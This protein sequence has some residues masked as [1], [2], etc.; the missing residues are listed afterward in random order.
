MDRQSVQVEAAHRLVASAIFFPD[1]MDKLVSS[2][3][4]QLKWMSSAHK[5]DQKA[6]RHHIDL[7]RLDLV[8]QLD[9]M[10]LK[11]P[12]LLPGWQER[13]RAVLR[14][15]ISID[16][17]DTFELLE[18]LTGL[19][20]RTLLSDDD[21]AV[22]NTR[23]RVHAGLVKLL[24]IIADLKM[25]RI[26][27]ADSWRSSEF[28]AHWTDSTSNSDYGYFEVLRAIHQPQDD[29]RMPNDPRGGIVDPP[30]I[31]F[32]FTL[33]AVLIG[34]LGWRRPGLGLATWILR[35]MPEDGAV[36]TSVKRIWGLHSAGLLHSQGNSMLWKVSL[37]V[38]G[39]LAVVSSAQGGMNLVTRLPSAPSTDLE[40]INSCNRLHRDILSGASS[41]HLETH[42]PSVLV[43]NQSGAAY[44]PKSKMLYDTS[45]NSSRRASL[46]VTEGEHWYAEL[47]SAGRDLPRR[48][49]GRSWRVNVTSTRYGYIGEFRQSR[50]TGLWFSGKHS[51]HMLGN[52]EQ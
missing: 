5:L 7:W 1:G 31:R 17:L 25:L 45:A 42:V 15:T 28:D 49:D 19:S 39:H 12:L 23:L 48:A 30:Y 10:Y 14:G 36:L 4:E 35:G 11:I 2:S 50:V 21:W 13:T 27:T 18:C 6:L 38:F 34:H 22:T 9:G 40:D 26:A 3:S 46:L 24:E 33:V 8:H 29:W 52:S 32:W 41:L 20:E 51:S 44:K 47:T 43:G 16:N 37:D